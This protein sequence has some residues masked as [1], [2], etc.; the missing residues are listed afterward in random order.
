M[1]RYFIAAIIAASLLLPV[2]ALAQADSNFGLDQLS[3]IE[4]GR[5]SL[6]DTISSIVNIVLGILGIVAFIIILYGGFLW[7]TSKGDE[8]QV[9]KAKKVIIDGVIGLAIILASWAIA[10]FVM[11]LLG[12]GTGINNPGGGGEDPGGGGT[13]TFRYLM[14]TDR[15]PDPLDAPAPRNSLVVVT[16]NQDLNCASITPESVVL[17]R[18]GTV[19]DNVHLRC[20]GRSLTIRSGT[21]CPAPLDREPVPLAEPNTCGST[22]PINQC[23]R[24]NAYF[25]TPPAESCQPQ[26]PAAATVAQCPGLRS[27]G[28]Y[29][30]G[31]YTLL[32]KGGTRSALNPNVL[33]G[34]DSR[35]R[36][37]QSDV[38]WDFTLSNDL[39]TEAPRI[40]SV[41]PD[42]DTIQPRNINVTV[43]F[44]KAIDPSTI[45]VFANAVGP[46]QVT[47]PTLATL[48]ITQGGSPVAGR[49]VGLTT[50]SVRW[51]PTGACGGGAPASCGCFD[52]NANIQV[53]V[54]D[55]ADG[56]R[57]A[58]CMSLDT[59]SGPAGMTCG[60]DVC[61][62]NF[63]TNGSVDLEAPTLNR[64]Q[65]YPAENATDVDRALNVGASWP[66]RVVATLNDDSGIA[67]DS[68]DY[69]TY[70]MAN[71]VP[72]RQVDAGAILGS[73]QQFG[74]LP[75]TEVLAPN[76]TYLP[77]LYGT[78]GL[79]SD[80]VMGVQD[81]AGNALSGRQRWQFRTGDSVNGGSP[82]ITRVSPNTGP[83]GQCVTILGYNLGCYTGAGDGPAQIGRWT[84]TQCL[85][86]AET[87]EIKVT[88]SSGDLVD[89]SAGDILSWDE[90]DRPEACTPGI[91][92]SNSCQASTCGSTCGSCALVPNPAADSCQ[93]PLPQNYA[94]RNQIIMTVPTAAANPNPSTPADVVVYPAYSS[95]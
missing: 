82:L 64:T 30:A 71:D 87:G 61:S 52:P 76:R 10:V 66:G 62:Y 43:K 83:H 32:L 26:D 85:V 91:N 57:G 21:P 36:F 45:T 19:L 14:W 7:M 50:K 41:T 28:C 81:N 48:L 73:N 58:S 51:K 33:E 63:R 35:R 1:R 37:M 67:L 27:C 13:N 44:T 60:G 92:C 72:T 89:V 93:C 53:E 80:E 12:R 54:H 18:G 88:N 20:S 47:D 2:V 56:I 95:P 90:V 17:S 78:G 59:T 11:N 74:L 39:D 46:N 65:L 69:S 25:T 55:G 86:A 70:L 31:T 16:F 6:V 77:S 75:G 23:L 84:G 9:S 24:A 3:S 79:C 8:K 29:T 5:Q 4:I 34:T 40:L 68:V 38:S 22:P 49:I 42:P 15:S 94:T